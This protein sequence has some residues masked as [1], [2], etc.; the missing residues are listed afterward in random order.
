MSEGLR[1]LGYDLQPSEAAILMQQ[2]DLNS[3]GQVGRGACPAAGPAS[4]GATARHAPAHDGH[5]W[6][7]WP[8]RLSA[9]GLLGPS[10]LPAPLRPCHAS[11]VC[12][13]AT[14]TAG[15]HTSGHPRT[16]THTHLQVHAPEFVA[17]QMDWAALQESNRCAGRGRAAVRLTPIGLG[18]PRGLCCLPFG[19]PA[20]S[21]LAV[22]HTPARRPPPASHSAA[23]KKV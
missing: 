5:R 21:A 10:C 12:S 14:A 22:L 20:A 19:G 7:P 13:T 17:S 9:G 15:T 8:A 3:D 11:Q 2:L 1:Q 4:R 16:H 6:G 23:S 18:L